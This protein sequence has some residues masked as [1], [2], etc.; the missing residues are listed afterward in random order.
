MGAVSSSTP[1]SL[2]QRA[3]GSQDATLAGDRLAHS[4]ANLGPALED[5]G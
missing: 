2:Q 1:N 4:L 5:A 3:G